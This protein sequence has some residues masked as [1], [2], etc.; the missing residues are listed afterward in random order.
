MWTQEMIEGIRAQL[1]EGWSA[2]MGPDDTLIV[3]GPE[4][5]DLE[6]QHWTAQ[7]MVALLERYFDSVVAAD[8]LDKVTYTVILPDDRMLETAK[9]A[10]VAHGLRLR[11]MDGSR[12]RVE[13]AS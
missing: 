9:A 12:F 7:H 5:A 2:E 3:R 13:A 11:R 6:M 8:N 4:G 1:P 10:A